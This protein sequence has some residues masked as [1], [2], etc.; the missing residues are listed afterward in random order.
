MNG[1]E[2]KYLFYEERGRSIVTIP[3]AIIESTN[4]NWE[5][6]SKIKIL[7][8]EIDGQKGLFLWKPEKKT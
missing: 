2:T 3:R 7:L 1:H 4:L 8:K 6:K 5:H